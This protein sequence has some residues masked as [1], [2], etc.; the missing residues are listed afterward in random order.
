METYVCALE[1]RLK[2]TSKDC[3]QHAY[4]CEESMIKEKKNLLQYFLI[5][6]NNF[7]R[8]NVT[9]ESRIAEKK[10]KFTLRM[11]NAQREGKIFY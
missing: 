11:K 3:K 10:K 2:I 6:E 5:I 9:K 1:K 7:V 4:I 8:Y